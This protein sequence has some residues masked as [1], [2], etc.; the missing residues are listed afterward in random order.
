MQASSAGEKLFIDELRTS[1]DLI[2]LQITIAN[3]IAAAAQGSSSGAQDGLMTADNMSPERMASDAR[4]L[5]SRSMDMDTL[6]NTYAQPYGMWD[7]CLRLCNA[8]NTVPLEY[9][10]NLWDLLLKHYWETAQGADG[11]VDSD[12]RLTLCCERTQELGARF[13][14]N[15]N[16]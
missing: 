5:R 1:V 13:Y 16:R 2:D 10:R 12:V 8:A 11:R 3:R 7:S 14:P 4:A 6:Y 15:E 9:V